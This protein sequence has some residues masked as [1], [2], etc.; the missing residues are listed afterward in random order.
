[1]NSLTMDLRTFGQYLRIYRAQYSVPA[2]AEGNYRATLGVFGERP[3]AILLLMKQDGRL[4]ELGWVEAALKRGVHEGRLYDI[5]TV[6]RWIVKWRTV[7]PVEQQELPLGG[8]AA[9][10]APVPSSQYEERAAP[11]TGPAPSPIARDFT[12]PPLPPR[13]ESL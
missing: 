9:P 5:T 3:T 11:T 12:P 4:P 10:P 2:D 7:Q 1:M 13:P 6:D 8:P